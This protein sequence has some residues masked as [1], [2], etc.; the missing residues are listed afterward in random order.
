MSIKTCCLQEI[1]PGLRAPRFSSHFKRMDLDRVD[2][3]LSALAPSGDL[4][5]RRLVREVLQEP[6]AACFLQLVFK[7]NVSTTRIRA[8]Y[9]S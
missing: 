4:E 6:N 2:L 3:R 7:M 9:I 8:I 5:V 1:T